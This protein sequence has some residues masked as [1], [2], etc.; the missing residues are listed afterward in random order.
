MDRRDSYSTGVR[1]QTQEIVT[2]PNF[3]LLKSYM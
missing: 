3:A 1:L 2:L